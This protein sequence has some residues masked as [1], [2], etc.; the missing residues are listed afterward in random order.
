MIFFS[1][2]NNGASLKRVTIHHAQID[3]KFVFRR[4]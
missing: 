1:I 4:D 3:G 2:A